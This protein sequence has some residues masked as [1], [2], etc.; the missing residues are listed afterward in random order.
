VSASSPPS[1]DLIHT[2]KKEARRDKKT[3]DNRK[4]Y[5]SFEVPMMGL[6]ETE[7][8]EQFSS[9]RRAAAQHEF[10]AEEGRGESLELDEA[11]P[12]RGSLDSAY[13]RI[14]AQD[15]IDAALEEVEFPNDS[16]IESEFDDDYT[17]VSASSTS[18]ASSTTS[19][20]AISLQ[21]DDSSESECEESLS[22]DTVQN[23]VAFLSFRGYQ[24]EEEEGSFVGLDGSMPSLSSF[25]QDS[26]ADLLADGSVG[27]NNSMPSLRS[28]LSP[29]SQSDSLRSLL[30]EQDSLQE[31]EEGRFSMQEN[32]R[33]P[34]S[35]AI[36]TENDPSM[37]NL[38]ELQLEEDSCSTRDSENLGF[39]N[40]KD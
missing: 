33:L 27:P 1:K 4:Q 21:D 25:N 31:R 2:V 11:M 40:K 39:I 38:E 10:S 8:A 3:D 35:S 28:W 5:S 34:L 20:D 24:N 7:D 9:H 18:I 6:E 12:R 19:S 22:R 17:S 13:S 23:A 37:P 32:T 30:S 26:V 14:S 16:D 36:V 15:Y 29:C